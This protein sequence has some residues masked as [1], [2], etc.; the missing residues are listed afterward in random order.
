VV[1]AVSRTEPFL[2]GGPVTRRVESSMR[3]RASARDALV[4]TKDCLLVCVAPD[5]PSVVEEVLGR[6]VDTLGPGGGWRAGVGRPQQGPGGAVRSFEQARSALDI[7]RRLQLPGPVHSA[8][9]LLVYQVLS[10]DS[11][12]LTDLVE[13]VLEPLRAARTG[14]AALL[15]T[16]SAYFA[17]GGVAT[18]AA[19]ELHVGVRT[20][21]YRLD[22][23]RALTGYSVHDP[24]QSF[25]LRVAVLGARLLD[26]PPPS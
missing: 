16:L 14:P 24:Q 18:A 9:D 23:I 2:D 8:S 17:A 3:L 25:T 12:A 19:R 13:A 22:R 7:G 4:T 6:V 15:D 20:V 1:V 11:A 10:R 5:M 26:W 21:T